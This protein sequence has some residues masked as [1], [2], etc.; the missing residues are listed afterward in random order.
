[1]NTWNSVKVSLEDG[2]VN[3]VFPTISSDNANFFVNAILP[4]HVVESMDLNSY[5]DYFALVPVVDGC[6]KIMPQS[7]D[8]NSLIFDVNACEDTKFA[9]YQVKNYGSFENFESFLE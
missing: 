1:M 2:K 3:V 7:K 5:K 6:A 4:K 8:V 9:Y